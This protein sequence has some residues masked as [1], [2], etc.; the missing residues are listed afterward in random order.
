V[1]PHEEIA[2]DPDSAPTH[3][4]PSRRDVLAGG[5]S[6]IA[7]VGGLAAGYGAFA[8]VSA[9]YLFPAR[10]RELAWMFVTEQKACEMA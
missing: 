9:R 6:S 10:P 5:A 2:M 4:S 3:S 7:M 8:L 1:N